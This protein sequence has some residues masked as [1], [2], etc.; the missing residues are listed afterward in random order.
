ME[1]KELLDRCEYTIECQK[2]EIDRLR[3]EVQRLLDWINGDLDA[4]TVLASIYSDPDAPQSNRVKAAAASLPFEKGKVLSVPPPIQFVEL[5][6]LAEL[7]EARRTRQD[8]LEG[9]QLEGKVL[10]LLSLPSRNGN[11]GAD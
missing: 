10:D 7:L 9:N 8:Q 1:V 6:P 4:H 11:G 5:V 2:Q 3:A